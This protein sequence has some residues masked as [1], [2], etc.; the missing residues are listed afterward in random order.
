[1]GP[2]LALHTPRTPCRVCA[3]FEDRSIS[4]SRTRTKYTYDG[5]R[6]RVK[7]T[8]G[9]LYWRDVA[10]NVIAETDLSGNNVNEYVFLNG[11]RVV[12]RKSTGDTY[13]YQVDQLGSVRAITTSTGAVC[14]DTDYSPY[15]QEFSHTNTCAQ[16]YKFT[17][18]ERDSETGLD[19]AFN[20]YYD[21]RI[22]RFMSSD[23]LGPA[24]ANYD[25]P[26]S[27][28]RYAYVLNNPMS[29]ADPRG[30][31]CVYLNDAGDGYESIDTNSNSDECFKNG[32]I[33]ADGT[34]TTIS[35]DPDSNV[36]ELTTD[37]VLAFGIPGQQSTLIEFGANDLNSPEAETL[38]YGF[39][40]QEAWQNPNSWATCAA[41]TSKQDYA[42]GGATMAGWNLWQ[43]AIGIG[44]SIGE[45]V[46][47]AVLGTLVSAG[48]VAVSCQGKP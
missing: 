12:R 14:Y 4:E 30:L 21:S 42:V 40:W 7:K 38:T 11:R 13:Y 34:V 1:M 32:G 37:Q 22:G 19:Y 39:H 10:G 33:W 18:Y 24:S 26:Q 41:D 28:N 35:I 5:N 44:V 31:D 17:G 15:G 25:D 27:M 36:V 6:M 43:R 2:V 23:P 48:H 47:T 20:R 16:N 45:N 8:G 29:S 3:F 9:T 46:R